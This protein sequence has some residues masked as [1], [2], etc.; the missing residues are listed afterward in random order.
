[1]PYE[2]RTPFGTTSGNVSPDEELQRR[3]SVQMSELQ[4]RL[5][6]QQ[7]QSA[8]NRYGVDAQRDIAGTFANR[9]AQ[10]NT[11]FDKKAAFDTGMFDK[12]AGHE[13]G[14]EGLRGRN[15]LDRTRITMG[16]NQ[17]YA[18]IAE[19]EYADKAPMRDVQT[20]ALQRA[21]SLMGG[22]AAQPSDNVLVGN[23][24]GGA[25]AGA[26]KWNELAALSAMVN[27]GS[28]PDFAA[29]E[30]DAQIDALKLEE[31]KRGMA[32]GRVSDLVGAGDVA[33]ARAEGARSGIPV[34]VPS[35]DEYLQNEGATA[36]N[37]L[38]NQAKQF[39]ER[40]R[41]WFTADPSGD[42]EGAILSAV[43]SLAEQIVKRTGIPMDQAL[44][45]AQRVV[46][47]AMSGADVDYA[48]DFGGDMTQSLLGK[49]R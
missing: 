32:R 1:M 2:M 40:D 25:P 19:R 44:K 42:D 28:M 24:G 17:T 48:T 14:M 27:G 38:G 15:E 35:A 36:V 49:L 46:Q 11:M 47:E 6:M 23:G 37:Q 45:R 8:D 16:P 29:R 18:N 13:M 7:M 34:A 12:K 21:L 30:R 20:Q 10:D 31:A 5:A 39:G 33:G 3:Q 22:G 4:A 26:D 41:A 9:A 43:Q